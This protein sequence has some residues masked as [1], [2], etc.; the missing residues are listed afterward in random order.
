VIDY[1]IYMLDP[2]GIITSWNAGAERIKG[3]QA[4]EVVGQHFSKFYSPEDRAAGQP[5]KSLETARQAGRFEAE[6]WRVRKDGTRF[7]ASVVI[8][9]IH[10]NGELIGFAKI[11]RDITERH[12][13]QTA[14]L[15][16]ERHFRLLVSGVTDYALYMLDPA[17]MVTNW[18]AGGQNIKGYAAS[19]VIGRHFSLFYTD[20]D[21]KDG[22][23][24]RALAIAQREGRYEDEG[25]R[26]R[27]DGSFFW[28]SVIIDALRDDDG[29]LIGF[30]KITRDITER[31]EAQLALEK[32]QRQLAESQKMDA[33]GQLTGGVAHD[34]NNLLMVVSG[35]IQTLKLAARNDPKAQRAVQA[36][37][38]AAQRGAAL[39][40]QLLTF[41]RRQRVNPE[42]IDVG[43]RIDMIR[44]VL[45]SGLGSSASLLTDIAPNTW[46]ITVD[47]T[48]FDT[49]LVNLVVNA[50]DAMPDGGT[51]TLSAK[52]ARIEDLD[53]V[54]ITIRDTGVG[55]PQDVVS[56]IFDPFFTTKPV[57]K[58]TGLGLSQVHGFAHQAGGTVSVESKLGEG[59]SFTLYLPRGFISAT[60]PV[61][62][63]AGS[64]AGTGTV[65]LVEDNPDVASAS[66]GLLEQLGYTV[67]WVT[68]ADAALQEIERN[69]IDI[70]F[71]DIV[72]PGRMDGIH[73]AHAVRQKNPGLPILLSTGYSEAARNVLADFPILRKPYQLHEL[74]RALADLRR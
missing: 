23:P 46:P 9:A 49:A 40:K 70:V 43:Q 25:W 61:P 45:S 24:A 58:G 39:T 32:V 69:G 38:L 19:E 21:R 62:W 60:S 36:I 71:S 35:H 59:T 7:L 11:T 29:T 42:P 52:N 44:E 54:A 53:F 12:K 74:S 2:T 56:K 33:L 48:E 17:G 6:G 8:D 55:I 5:A 57:G 73:L 18:N 63:M 3:Y 51:V 4:H 67:R 41:S 13:A 34:F 22:R 27:K 47:A 16:S 31:R 30:A 37:E 72:M 15:E 26:V 10:E 1:A 28:A 20:A 50:R 66:T 68:S 64:S 65:L 14:L